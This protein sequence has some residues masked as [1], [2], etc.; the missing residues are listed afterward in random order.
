VNCQ[1]HAS[2]NRSK[3]IRESPHRSAPRKF[4]YVSRFPSNVACDAADATLKPGVVRFSVIKARSL[5]LHFTHVF[6]GAGARPEP[7]QPNSLLITL[8][9]SVPDCRCRAPAIPWCDTNP[10]S[11][12]PSAIQTDHSFHGT[13]LGGV[14]SGLTFHLP[15][16][17]FPFTLLLIILRNRVFSIRHC[18]L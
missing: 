17:C 8:V 11:R 2:W 16:L 14:I 4:R 15:V 13:S 10:P 9:S 7:A 18:R 1:R 5:S 3:P 12:R 6:C